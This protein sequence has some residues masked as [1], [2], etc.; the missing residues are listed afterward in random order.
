MPIASASAAGAHTISNADTAPSSVDSLE[1]LAGVAESDVTLSEGA[2]RVV[3]PDTYTDLVVTL[4]SGDTAT[5]R[6]FLR[7]GNVNPGP[8]DRFAFAEGATWDSATIFAILNDTA[9]T[10]QA[11]KRGVVNTK[12]LASSM[13]ACECVDDDVIRSQWSPP[14]STFGE[15]RSSMPTAT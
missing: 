14:G 12:P 15:P 11:D 6:D 4:T 3:G 9:P 5:I 2:I 13:T 1:F 8:V 7:N 10:L